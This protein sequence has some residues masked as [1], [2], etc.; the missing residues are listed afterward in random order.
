MYE[1]YAWPG[2]YSF[3]SEIKLFVKWFKGK[4]DSLLSKIEETDRKHSV[5]NK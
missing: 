3:K 2:A 1:S 4:I 5:E